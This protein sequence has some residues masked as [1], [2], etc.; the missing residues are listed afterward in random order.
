M[1][2][3]FVGQNKS[4]WS[5]YLDICVFAYDTSQQDSTRFTPFELM[6]S[7]KVTLPVDICIHKKSED[8]NDA[9]GLED[10]ERLDK[11]REKWLQKAIANIIAA[12]RKQKEHYDKKN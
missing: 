12:P 6:F 3:K 9:I 1:L 10:I 4:T 11:E 5:N 8:L 2:I 7:W